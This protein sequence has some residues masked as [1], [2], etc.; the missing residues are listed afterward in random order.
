MTVDSRN[1][2]RPHAALSACVR[3]RLFRLLLGSAAVLAHANASKLPAQQV[4]NDSVRMAHAADSARIVQALG[5]LRSGARVDNPE[6]V[7]AR[8]NLEV[9]GARAAASG[10]ANP[11]SLSAGLSEAPGRNIDQGNLRLEIGRDFLTGPRRRAERSVAQIEVQSAELELALALRR[12]DAE[13][14]RNAVFAV[15]NRNIA[16]RLR[17][18][19]ELLAGAEEG[20]RSRFGI[21]EARYTDVLR[22]RTE[23]LR[24]QS[25]RSTV[26][27][28]GRS[29][30]ADLAGIMGPGIT[31]A[32]LSAVIDT[33]SMSTLAE[34]WKTF[35]PPS[36][37]LD[38]L[39]SLTGDAQ[40]R[41]LD[42]ARATAAR[43]LTAAARKTQL[44]AF[45]GIQRIG[46]A[47]NGPTL[48]PSL[49]VTVSLPFTAAKSNKLNATAE[50]LAIAAANTAQRVGSSSTRAA[51]EAAMER[52]ES[53][54]SRLETFD[55]TL[56]QGARD[57][58]TSALAAF[59]TG[60][61]SLI[62]LLD[63]ERAIARAEIE[64]LHALM[65]AVDAWAD[66]VGGESPPS[67]HTSI[68]PNGR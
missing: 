45:A 56:L 42:Y 59:R 3:S 1:L 61:M 18:E 57:E 13:L 40:R 65:D 51:L 49:G 25:E 60:E 52:F 20:V 39:L 7:V 35:V 32:S 11:A 21:G 5:R 34:V 12:V 15:A 6:V 28:A 54:R 62:D 47:N 22:L 4:V 41:A 38:S 19:D 29:S 17:A 31:R 50:S 26:I 66:L 14:L 37:P 24:V 9:A 53:A 16:E 8:A 23:R 27:A 55:A 63:F 36:P 48:G 30:A 68:A 46:Q 67:T 43:D 44:S 64:R 2:R 10:L 58:R 33:L